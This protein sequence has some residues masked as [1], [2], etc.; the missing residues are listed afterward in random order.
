[1][2]KTLLTFLSIFSIAIA[3]GAQTVFAPKITI[4]SATG[5]NPYTIASG[6]IDDNTNLDIVIGTDADHI[7]VWYKGNGDGTFIKQIAITNTLENISGLKL[8]DLNGDGDKDILA[9][10]FGSYA[11]ATYGVGSKLV[12]FE[13]DGSGNFGTEQ[14]IYDALNGM[15]G[16]FVGTIDTGST[17]DIAVTAYVSGQ[18]FWLSNDGSG[19]FSAPSI[20]DNTLSSPGIVNMKDIDN[21][22]DLDALIGTAAYAGDV[23]EIFRNNL[24]PSGTVSFTKDITSVST[25]KVGFFNAS[26]EDLD[27]DANLDILATEISYGGGP[28]GNLYWYED[29]GAGYTETTFTT[30]TNNPSVAQVKDLDNDG[31]ADIILSSGALADVV[32]LVWFKNNGSGSFG[33]EQVIDNTQ[34]QVYVYNVADFDGDMDLD[35]ASNAYGANQLNYIENQFETLSIIDNELFSVKIFPNPT[36]S[37]LN[38]EGFYTPSINISIIDILGK[39]VLE[40]TLINGES[41]DVSQLMNGVYSIKIN[42]EFA[43]KFIKE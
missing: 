1:M 26:F 41:I 2:V 4:D 11:G 25:G 42:N 13:N 12:W 37:I 28:S 40:K 19:N 30:S 18:V 15:S 38:F 34:S 17:R 32:D 6:F 22:G 20:I 16:L 8:I 31:L 43:S 29:N 33:A 14:L 39:Q 27:G 23:L 35:I 36:K 21:D 7:I 10:G 3:V 5:N 9:V 24:V